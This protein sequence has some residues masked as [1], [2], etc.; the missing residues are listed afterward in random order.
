[1]SSLDL[2][3]SHLD[4]VSS[5]EDYLHQNQQDRIESRLPRRRLSSIPCDT[6]LS[7]TEEEGVDVED[8]GIASRPPIRGNLPS[9]RS[10]RRASTAS[11]DS[12]AALARKSSFVDKCMNRVKTLIKK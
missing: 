11:C 2:P 10:S 1:M 9:G 5:C 6:A 12:A 8:H 7:I 3:H 4:V